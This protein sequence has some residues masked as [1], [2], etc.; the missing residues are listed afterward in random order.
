MPRR[1]GHRRL[2]GLHGKPGIL[3]FGSD[4]TITR[5][6]RASVSRPRA[7]SRVL[8]FPTASRPSRPPIWKQRFGP[9]EPGRERVVVLLPKA[10]RRPQPGCEPS[11]RRARKEATLPNGLE[12]LVLSSPESPVLA[13]HFFVRGRSQAEPSG[14]EGAV[15]LLHRMLPIRTARSDPALLTLRLRADGRGTKDSRR[16]GHSL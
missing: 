15:E 8:D 4:P 10:E 16:S 12:L 6:W 9:G 3:T 1:R 13:L 11:P 7:S 14:M 5:S 2:E